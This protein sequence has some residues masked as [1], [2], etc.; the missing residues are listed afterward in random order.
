MMAPGRKIASLDPSSDDIDSVVVH[1]LH[2]WTNDQD[3]ASLCHDLRIKVELGDIHF[4]EHKVNG[5]SKG[6][7][8]IKCESKEDA[9]KLH[10]HLQTQLFQGK[11]VSSAL[12][13]SVVGN[14][15]LPANQ[16]FPAVR[17]LSTAIHST[18]RHP[19][20]AHGGVNFNRVRPSSRSAIHANLGVGLPSNNTPRPFAMTNFNHQP[21]GNMPGIM[22][23]DPAVAWSSL[24][25]DQHLGYVYGGAYPPDGQDFPSNGMPMAY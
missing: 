24:R 16:D 15:L 7:A 17:P 5:K 1:D 25:A 22:Y 6:Q 9:L 23:S 14:P 11:K 19:T 2:W 4:L 12:A 8:A 20:N 10:Q 3:L 18:I 21:V 13:S